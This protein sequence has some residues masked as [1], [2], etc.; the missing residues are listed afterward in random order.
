M[1][2][3]PAPVGR[4]LFAR[5][6]FRRRETVLAIRGRV[7]HYDLLWQ[8]EGSAF[9][10][11]CIRFGPETYLDPGDGPARYLNHSCEPNTAVTKRAN[12]LY[13][14]AKRRIAR[15]EEI[16]FD[17]STTI[18]DDDL[19]RMRCRCGQPSC[20]RVIRNFGSLPIERRAYYLA[21]GFVPAFIV[22][23]LADRV[24]PR[25]FG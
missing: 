4:G 13:L 2:V 25:R 16:V 1:L 6:A 17:Y 9:S 10:A 7:V 12:R 15:G 24:S 22:R 18:G 5:R 8:R 11:N 20:R 3:A 19:W 23:T 21:N 14:V